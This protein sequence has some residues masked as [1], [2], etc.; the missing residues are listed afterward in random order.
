MGTVINSQASLEG[1][2]RGEAKCH[3]R[4]TDGGTSPAWVRR[5]R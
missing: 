3:A 1:D 2:D 5:R 4:G